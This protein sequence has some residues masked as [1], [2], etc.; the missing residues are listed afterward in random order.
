MVSKTWPMRF[1][2]WKLSLRFCAISVSNNIF[3]NVAGAGVGT[4]EPVSVSQEKT[5]VDWSDQ[6]RQ[7]L[8]EI[9]W[10]DWYRQR[11]EQNNR[12]I[13]QQ[14]DRKEWFG[15]WSQTT[16]RFLG[17]FL[18]KVHRTDCRQ[19]FDQFSSLHQLSIFQSK[20]TTNWTSFLR[21]FSHW[22]KALD[23]SNLKLM[24]KWKP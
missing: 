2:V 14:R 4:K 5:I 24:I 23:S 7:R 6:L 22:G 16:W 13:D 8:A 9:F 19:I 10:R 18:G 17:L 12:E 20:T 11:A 3:D 21:T 15:N 1:A